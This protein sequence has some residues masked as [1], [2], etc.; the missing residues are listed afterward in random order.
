MQI[1]CQRGL[2]VG[3][4]HLLV[5]QYASSIFIG[6]GGLFMWLPGQFGFADRA[7]DSRQ[8]Q[9]ALKFYY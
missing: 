9:F 6:I 2:S 8:V 4:R 1:D 3:A 5:M 7:R